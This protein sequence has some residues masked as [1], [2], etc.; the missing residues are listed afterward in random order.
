[1]GEREAAIEAATEAVHGFAPVFQA[2][3]LGRFGAK[4]GL[5]APT[6]ADLPLIEALL[7]RM[8][9][10]RAD[11]TRTFRGLGTGQARAE[12]FEPEAFDQWAG[13]WQARLAQ[14]TDPHAL[15][16]AANPVRI[17]RNHRIEAAITAAVAGDLAPFERLNSA[18]A[19]PFEDLPGFEDLGDAP[20]EDEVVW[21]TF[22]GT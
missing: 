5:A 12:F 21:R 10:L 15:M 13:T 18:L 3:W 6:E 2:E 14:E 16:A 22:C 8:A 20:T 17:P 9:T 1:M 11:F 19:R 4:I 7:S